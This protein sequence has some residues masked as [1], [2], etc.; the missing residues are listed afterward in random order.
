MSKARREIP[1]RNAIAAT[2]RDL[3]FT[4]AEASNH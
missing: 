2:A 4:P 1:N 3:D